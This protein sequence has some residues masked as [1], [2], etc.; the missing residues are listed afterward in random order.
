LKHLKTQTHRVGADSSEE[1]N[2]KGGSLKKRTEGS[3][4]K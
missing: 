1:W 4:T 2:G 3:R